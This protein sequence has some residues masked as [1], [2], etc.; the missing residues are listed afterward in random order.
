M[1]SKLICPHAHNC[2]VYNGWA[3]REGYTGTSVI[4]EGST[5]EGFRCMALRNT[6]FPRKSK[7]YYYPLNFE[8]VVSTVGCSHLTLLNLLWKRQ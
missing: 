3:K 8:K 4:L 5:S 6:E 1:T 7:D 2:D